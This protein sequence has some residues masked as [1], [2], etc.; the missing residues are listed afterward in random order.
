MLTLS[1][2]FTP[3][4]KEGV[5]ANHTLSLWKRAAEGRVK[6]PRINLTSLP[7]ACWRTGTLTPTLSQRERGSEGLSKQLGDESNG[8]HE[9]ALFSH[10]G[11][12]H[13]ERR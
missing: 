13:K 1:C 5:S 4:P 3:F 2:I 6:A 11:H 9:P 8:P 12:G 10:S 7:A